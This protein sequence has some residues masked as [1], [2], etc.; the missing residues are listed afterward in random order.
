MI[1][2]RDAKAAIQLILKEIYLQNK[3]PKN[4]IFII[5]NMLIVGKVR[6]QAAEARCIILSME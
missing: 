4:H 5:K 3:L 6:F 1:N 2:K